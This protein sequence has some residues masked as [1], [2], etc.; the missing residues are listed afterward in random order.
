MDGDVEQRVHISSYR[1]SFEWQFCQFWLGCRPCSRR[2]W[3]DSGALGVRYDREVRVPRSFFVNGL[4][5][6]AI[7]GAFF[8]A[9]NDYDC[10][11]TTLVGCIDWAI[12]SWSRF[13]SIDLGVRE[14]K[15]GISERILKTFDSSLNCVLAGIDFRNIVQ[16]SSESSAL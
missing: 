6:A 8:S 5:Q 2:S 3:P 16:T 7:Y 15:K 14:T 1:L 13:A 9:F 10:L 4:R 12:L 11:G